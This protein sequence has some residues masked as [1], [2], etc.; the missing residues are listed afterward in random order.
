MTGLLGKRGAQPGIEI[1]VVVSVVQ[2][3]EAALEPKLSLSTTAQRDRARWLQPGQTVTAIFPLLSTY[4]TTAS[5]TGRLQRHCGFENTD[6]EG[7][8][9]PHQFWP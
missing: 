9:R 4:V 5:H 6:G 3:L 7:G 1:F 2:Y 8:A